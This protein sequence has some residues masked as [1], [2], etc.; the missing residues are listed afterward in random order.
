VEID[1]YRTEAEHFLSELDREYYLHYSG[2]KESFEIE[3]VYDRHSQLFERDAVDRI[4]E[5]Y[6]TAGRGTELARQRRILL[7][8]AVEGHIGTQ[9]KAL[10]AE[11]ARR[12]A[13][14]TLEVDGTDVGYRQ[15]LVIQANTADPAARR[16]IG[17]Q[18]LDLID[19]EL[20]PVAGEIIQRQHITATELGFASYAAM[21]AELK[22]VD[23][24]GLATATRRFITESAARYPAVVGPELQAGLGYELDEMSVDD[25]GRFSR[26]TDLDSSFPAQ[27]LLPS[28]YETVG[29]LGIDMHAQPNVHLDV[30]ARPNKTPRA[31]CAPVRAP[32]EVYLVIAPSGGREDYNALF[33]EAGHTQHFAHMDRTLPFEYR[34]LGDSAIT[35]GFAFLFEHL[36]QNPRWL[37]RWVRSAE[38]EAVL[39]R[40][41]ANRAMMIRRYAAKLDYELDLHGAAPAVDPAGRYAELLSDGIGFPWPRERHLTD[42]DPGFYC[43]YYLRAWA[44]ETSLR[45]VLTE[46]FSE[47]WFEQPEAG[48]LLREWWSGG[49][50]LSAEEFLHEITGETLDFSVLLEDLN[51]V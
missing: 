19:R 28:L 14:L 18:L 5:A 40:S 29:G 42:V 38:P 24:E 25:F 9:T 37:A 7:D 33:H 45:R 23:L 6:D 26:A 27:R 11:M 34:Y 17:T 30:E 31:F 20:N 47:S 10:E 16:V 35:E 50:R 41:V 1:S 39:R 46:R 32:D 3:A 13:G 36:E 49:Q 48:E 2:I 22:G 12:E 51:L 44:L 43:A 15:A 4:R 8:F 21:C